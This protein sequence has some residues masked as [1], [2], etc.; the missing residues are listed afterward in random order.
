M[1]QFKREQIQLLLATI[2]QSPKS[3]TTKTDNCHACKNIAHLHMRWAKMRQE[4]QCHQFNTTSAQLLTAFASIHQPIMIHW[5]EKLI[6]MHILIKNYREYIITSSI[7]YRFMADLFEYADTWAPAALAN[8]SEQR[9]QLINQSW[10][11]LR[12]YNN[13]NNRTACQLVVLSLV[14]E[15]MQAASACGLTVSCF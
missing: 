6:K 8:A 5:E 11:S 13:S 9:L 1:L 3:A 7:F 12:A 4:A 10:A 14:L 15:L 2:N